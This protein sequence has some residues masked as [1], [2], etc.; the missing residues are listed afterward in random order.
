V[1]KLIAFSELLKSVFGVSSFEDYKTY[2]FATDDKQ[3][4]NYLVSILNSNT[5]D[6]KI[7]PHQS[8]G[9]FGPRDI[10]RLP[11]EFNIPQFDKNREIH[12]QI[13]V[14]GLK[15]AKEATK[16][17]KTSRSKTKNALPQMKEIDTLVE[18]LLK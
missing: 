3:E 2:W 10:C 18:E 13:A 6:K 12:K 11:F 17:P 7:K 4:A 8:R 15:A 5:L 14:L 1:G 16:L 9:K